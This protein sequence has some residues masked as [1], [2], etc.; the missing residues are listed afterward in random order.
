MRRQHLIYTL[1][2]SLLLGSGVAMLAVSQ[3]KSVSQLRAEKDNAF[4]D[5]YNIEIP[6]HKYAN[7][8]LNEMIRSVKSKYKTLSG[9]S[10]NTAPAGDYISLTHRGGIRDQCDQNVLYVES[11]SQAVVDQYGEAARNSRKPLGNR[12]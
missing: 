8:S 12:C 6:R 1:A 2:F 3:Q 4:H 5:L 9:I 11:E 7:D 10:V